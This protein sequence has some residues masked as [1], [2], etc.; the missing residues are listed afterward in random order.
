MMLLA[1]LLQQPA[2]SIPHTDRRQR[3]CNRWMMFHSVLTNDSGICAPFEERVC[4]PGQLSVQQYHQWWGR[5]DEWD[6]STKCCI[7]FYL[8]KLLGRSF[9]L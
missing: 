8:P 9:V 5:P 6:R 3:T 4:K 2:G 1:L 7:A